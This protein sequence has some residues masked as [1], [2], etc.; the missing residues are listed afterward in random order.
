MTKK[1]RI[2]RD[3]SGLVLML[4]LWTIALLA[5]LGTQLVSAGRTELRLVFAMRDAALVRTAADGAVHEAI[6]RLADGGAPHW[7]AD[8]VPRLTRIGGVPVSVTIENLSG[9]LNPNTAP[10]DLIGAVLTHL[11]MEPSRA[12]A[13]GAAVFDWHMPGQLPSPGGAKLPAYRAAGLTYGPPGQPFEND[14]EIGAV[15]GMTPDI[16]A[17]LRPFLSVYNEG[18]IEPRFAAPIL[19]LA[20]E[21]TGTNQTAGQNSSETVEI[22]AVATGA[23]DASYSRRAVAR[24]RSGEPFQILYWGTVE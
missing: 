19:R 9:R 21:E 20:L 15:L 1:P 22:V 3:Q 24:F 4:V 23:H 5:L 8:R 12:L 17:A 10:G 13:Q 2:A 16:A 7:P 18:A 11:G 14:A 6:W